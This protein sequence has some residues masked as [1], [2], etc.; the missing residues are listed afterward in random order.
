[1]ARSSMTAL[2]EGGRWRFV[3][4]DGHNSCNDSIPK[5]YEICAIMRLSHAE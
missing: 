3:T 2:V 5:H 4:L 1:M